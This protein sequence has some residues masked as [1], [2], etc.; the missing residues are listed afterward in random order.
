MR[1]RFSSLRLVLLCLFAGLLLLLPSG[2]AEAEGL[3]TASQNAAEAEKLPISSFDRL[4]QTDSGVH[5]Q[6]YNG[7]RLGVLTGTLMEDAAKKYFPD[8]EY[9]LL[10]SYPDCIAAL[11][12]GK[13]DAYLADESSVKTIHAEQPEI[14]YIHERLTQND[15]CFAFR[16]NDERSA[17]LCEELNEFI[18]RSWADGTMQEINDTWFGVDE[19]RKIVDMSDLTGVNGTI[20][21]ITTSTDMPWSYIKDG[22]N[23]GYDIDLVVRFC[24]DR[25]Y[26]MELGDVDFSGRIPGIESGKYDFT[27][28]M[29]VTPERAEQVLFS[30]PTSYGG[31][32]LAVLSSDLETAD[33]PADGTAAAAGSD[34]SFTER[35]GASF[36]KTFLRENRWK[37]FLQG[38]ETTLVITVLAVLFGTALGFGVFLLCRN[39]SRVANTVTRFF[40]WLVQGMPVVVLLMVLYYVIFGNTDISAVAVAVIGFTLAF[41]SAV[42]GLLRMGVGA[43]DKGQYEA[44]YALGYSNPKTFFKII[45]PQALPHISNAY[46]GEIV[47]LI[48]ATAVVGYIAVQDLTKMGDIVRSRTYEAFFPLIS[49]TIFY[50]LLEG[51]IGLLISRID[52]SLNP[53]RRKPEDI[54]KGVRTDDQN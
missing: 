14:D 4:G 29:N 2:A 42:F 10:N 13:I 8:S 18:V 9:L 39:G 28:D 7:K 47:S 19:D 53:R 20:K 27:T 52:V 33:A 17:A 16:K 15:Y 54:L 36:E 50:F 38:I 46:R 30:K 43:V 1:K 51:L 40:I 31:I 26:A 12:S 24:R 48:K 3:P 45:L 32:V 5:W 11:R 49:V 44:A 34:N 21:V 41:G 6:D 23:V 35:I 37:L 25:G 22:K